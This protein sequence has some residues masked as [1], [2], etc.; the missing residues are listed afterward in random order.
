MKNNLEN[1]WRAF[2][3]IFGHNSYVIFAG[4]SA[5]F[6]FSF[7][8]WLPNISLIV[9]IFSVSSIPFSAKFKIIFSLLGGIGTNFSI[10][11][12]LY[13]ISISVL[14]GIVIAMLLYSYRKKQGQIGGNLLTMGFG[15]ISSGALGVGCAAC[16]SFVLTSFLSFIGAGGALTLLP[17]K[18]GEFG[19]LSVV[20]LL[21]LVFIISKKNFEPMVCEDGRI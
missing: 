14:F 7:A 11:S 17:L 21:A 8:V 10:V 6:A 4:I 19:I 9:D 12:A 15:G 3:E 18:G 2:K 13:T 16:G 5:L 20:L 1:V